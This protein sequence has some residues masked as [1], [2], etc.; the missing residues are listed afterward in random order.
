MYE[1]GKLR[2]AEIQD[3]VKQI[4]NDELTRIFLLEQQIENTWNYFRNKTD[5]ENLK[6]QTKKENLDDRSNPKHEGRKTK[7]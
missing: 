4:L 6:K 5:S 3:D 2:N 7:S 1:L